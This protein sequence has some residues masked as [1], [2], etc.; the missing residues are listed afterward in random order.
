[1]IVLA[2]C[3]PA[4]TP[5]PADT[6]QGIVWQWTSLTN[7]TTKE[8]TTISTSENY[9]I[10]FNADDTLFGKAECNNVTGPTSQENGFTIEL[11]AMAM[12]FY[13]EGSLD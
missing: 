9:T 3:A 1:M 12:A 8:T 13:G 6:I 7:K 10:T 5:T 2:A 4:A 11:G